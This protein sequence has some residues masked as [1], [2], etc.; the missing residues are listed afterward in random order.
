[1]TA[2]H[3]QGARQ[4]TLEWVHRELAAVKGSLATLQQRMDQAASLAVDS[5]DKA[6]QLRFRLDQIEVQVKTIPFLQEELRATREQVG[7]LHDELTAVRQ[8]T[9]ELN[10][11]RQED[12][13]RASDERNQIAHRFSEL[14]RPI[15]AWREKVASYDEQHR[16]SIEAEAQLSLKLETLENA[17]SA[18]A[19]RYAR[20]R[21]A[22]GRMDQELTRLTGA[23]ETLIQE[24]EALKER[25][26]SAGEFLRRLE[27]ETEALGTQIHRVD[28]IDDRLE[29]VQ[30]E[31]SRH[32]ERLTELTN[33]IQEVNATQ[34]DQ[35]EHTSLLEAR[36]AAFQNELRG[37]DDKLND[38]REKLAGYLRGT[39]QSEGEFRKRN[40]AALEKEV[41]EIRGRAVDFAEE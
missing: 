24:D 23:L 4:E 35:T 30:A 3:E 2:R 31:R 25:L 12:V 1:M 21:N 32:G 22:V 17:Q 27:S 10:R 40:I 16:R 39:N 14:T 36:M 13:E 34:F 20:L 37:L 28:R 29:L 38:F 7:K 19:T 11:H 33:A 6:D 9:E 8:L 26:Q 18:E 15:G 5:A 41:R